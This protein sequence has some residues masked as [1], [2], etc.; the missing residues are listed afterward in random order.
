M[1][2]YWIVCLLRR[3]VILDNSGIFCA[4][5]DGMGDRGDEG[6]RAVS[7]VKFNVEG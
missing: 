7:D 3:E 1:L 6:V 4:F 5:G 2:I